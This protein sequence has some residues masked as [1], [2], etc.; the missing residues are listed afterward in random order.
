M[1]IGAE[2]AAALSRGVDFVLAAQ[3]ADG[4][5]S[6]WALPPG[7]SSDWITAQV[8]LRLARIGTRERAALAEPLDR[9]A[10]W[11]LSRQTESGGWGYSPA[12]EPDAD[13]TAQVLL[14]LAL[15]GH[16][17]P[18]GAC[19]FLSR[20]QRPDGG[21]ATF[22]PDSLMGSW[23][24]SHSEITAAALLAL[25]AHP[26]GLPQGSF[27]R[28]L[29]WLLKARRPDGLWNS[30]WWTTPLPATEPSLA[31]LADLG[32]PD[33][34]PAALARWIPADSLEAA[35]VLSMTAHEATPVRLDELA[36][37]LLAEQDD[38]GSWKGA[39]ALRLPS[40]DCQ[41]PW[42]TGTSSPLFADPQ[43]LHSTATAIAA[44]AKAERRLAGRD[45]RS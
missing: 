9:A 14:F 23:C 39:P 20:H 18:R 4:A 2:I 31:L 6:D 28:G 12:V 15:L 40:R 34:P 17:A 16:P 3:S 21:F 10:R 30:F 11:L 19:A 27:A 44:L 26:G 24:L 29:A 37:E 25:R 32:T 45:W 7:P 13:S 22:E 5:W 33:P 1:T 41:H 36:R 42:D 35:L 38:D 43:R 8:G